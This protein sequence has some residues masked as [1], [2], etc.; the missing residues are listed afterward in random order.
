MISRIYNSS[1]F[2]FLF[3]FLFFSSSCFIDNTKFIGTVSKA[4][5]PLPSFNLIDQNN[6]NINDQSILPDNLLIVFLYSNCK[7]ECPVALNDINSIKDII[8]TN[9]DKLAV[10]VFS[11]DPNES[12]ENVNTVLT[13]YKLNSSITYLTGNKDELK[14]I[15]QYFYVPVGRVETKQSDLNLI[16]HSI[17]AYIISRDNETTLIYTEFNIDSIRTDLNKLLKLN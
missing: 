1:F 4:Y 2:F 6:N 13:K 15:W 10:I 11:I 16:L 14:D 12:I 3:F 5:K 8:D 17:P 7:T 9:S